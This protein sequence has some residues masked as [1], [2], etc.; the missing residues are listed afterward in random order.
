MP[1]L[2]PLRRPH[3]PARA[4]MTLGEVLVAMVLMGLVFTMALPF[5]TTQARSIDWQAGRLDA[6][7]NVRFGA[8][9][10]E[11]DLRSAGVGVVDAQPMVVEAG[12][13]AVTFN[14][15]LVSRDSADFGAVMNDP[16]A[17]AASV[18]VWPRTLRAAL[19]VTGFVYPDST[20][21][22]GGPTGVPSRAETISYWVERDPSDPRTDAFRLMRR[23]NATTPRVVAR[24]LRL[25]PGE[26]VF[27]YFRTDASGAQTEIP[28]G[29]LPATHRA[30]LHGSPGDTANFGALVDSIRAVSVRLVGRM[31]D[32]RTSRTTL[33]TVQTSV[34]LMNAGLLQRD[35]CGEVPL[36][37]AVTLTAVASRVNGQPVITLGWA[38]MTDDRAGERDVERYLLLRRPLTEAGFGE[39]FVSVP[40]GQASYSYVDADLVPGTTYVYGVAGQ[41]CSPANSPVVSS[42]PV[43]ALP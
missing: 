8:S 6:Q 28:V 9:A 13:R 39:P 41:D 34:R 12:P 22:D 10:I 17:D 18:G 3:A 35:G 29:R 1:T 37:G 4:G 7:L 25:A 24:G 16:R 42:A 15:D 30:A 31:T 32:R 2:P 20:Y 40:A 21:R 27:R 11:R 26:A 38:A 14:A 36:V 19:P 23:V 33:D 43:T 5:M